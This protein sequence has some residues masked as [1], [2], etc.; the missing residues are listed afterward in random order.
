MVKNGCGQSDYRTPKLTVY[1]QNAQMEQADFL[2][3]VQ[4]QE[5]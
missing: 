3:L 5:S 4:I 2:M 1:L